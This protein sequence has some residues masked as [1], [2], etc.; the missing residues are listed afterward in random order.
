MNIA[1]EL[2]KEY[3]D[4]Q[5]LIKAIRKLA[6]IMANGVQNS[7]VSISIP[8]NSPKESSAEGQNFINSWQRGGLNLMFQEMIQMNNTNS[9][10]VHE[11]TVSDSVVLGVLGVLLSDKLEAN[12][13]IIEKL[14]SMGV[15]V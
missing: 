4:N 11:F 5:H 15:V 9:N 8:C 3:T 6:A 1:S 7:K 12:K 10:Q 13:V 14:K 2:F